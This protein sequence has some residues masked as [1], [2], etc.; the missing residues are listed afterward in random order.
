MAK[1]HRILNNKWRVGAIIVFILF[2]IYCINYGAEEAETTR[3][4]STPVQEEQGL[5]I[6]RVFIVAF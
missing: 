5:K 6:P 1:L 2:V 4:E 3:L